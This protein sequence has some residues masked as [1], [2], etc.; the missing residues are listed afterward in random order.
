MLSFD[1]FK[2]LN[3]CINKA[4]IAITPGEI[5]PSQQARCTKDG[6]LPDILP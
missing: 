3:E 4:S 5:A 2:Y 6:I 1:F